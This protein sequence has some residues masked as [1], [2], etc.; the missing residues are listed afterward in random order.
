MT[1]KDAV[2]MWAGVWVGIGALALLLIWPLVVAPMLLAILF[3]GTLYA[4]LFVWPE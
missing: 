4:A 3:L 2:L 1:R